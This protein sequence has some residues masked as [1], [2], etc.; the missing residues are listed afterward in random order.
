MASA[1]QGP[2]TS[3]VVMSGAGCPPPVQGQPIVIEG[4]V[5]GAQSYVEPVK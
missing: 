4:A 1:L 3:Q 5:M 2:M